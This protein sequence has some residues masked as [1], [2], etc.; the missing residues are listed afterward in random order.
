MLQFE[1]AKPGDLFVQKSDA[2]TIDVLGKAV[3]KLFG[4]TGVGAAV[5][6]R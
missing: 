6:A 2:S 5:L 4:D 3:Q 1:H